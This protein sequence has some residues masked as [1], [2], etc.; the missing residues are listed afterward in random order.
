MTR[1]KSR[2]SLKAVEKD[3]SHFV[4][5]VVPLGALGKRLETRCTNF[6]LGTASSPSADMV[7]TTQTERALLIRRQRQSSQVNLTNCAQHE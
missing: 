7:G 2:Q 6:T 4:D 1:Y 3:F 5:I